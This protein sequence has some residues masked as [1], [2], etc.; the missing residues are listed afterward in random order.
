MSPGNATI[1]AGFARDCRNTRAGFGL[2]CALL[3]LEILMGASAA[4][5]FWFQRDVGRRREEQD[6]LEK[7]EIAT[8]QVYRS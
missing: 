7:L 3:G 4:I 6:Q 2:L 1:P 5:G 8:K